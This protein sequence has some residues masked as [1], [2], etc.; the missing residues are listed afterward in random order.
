MPQNQ[1]LDGRRHSILDKRRHLVIAEMPA[2]SGHPLLHL[3]MVRPG[4]QHVGVVI[5]FDEQR[6]ATI[7]PS[8]HLG[9]DLAHDD[10]VGG[11]VAV[12]V[13]ENDSAGQN[14]IV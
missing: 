4:G 12:A 1:P 9:R 11:A 14:G 5:G 8:G 2:R 10:E 13:A 3:R 7:Q 6:S